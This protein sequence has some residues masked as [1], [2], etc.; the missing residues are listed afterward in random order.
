MAAVG[1]VA[2]DA[3]RSGRGML[4]RVCSAQLDFLRQHGRGYIIVSK[5]YFFSVRFHADTRPVT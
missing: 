2:C 5:S 3:H 4:V 1:S